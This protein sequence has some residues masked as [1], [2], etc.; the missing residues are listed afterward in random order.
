MEG[1]R[2]RVYRRLLAT[3]RKLHYAEVFLWVISSAKVPRSGSA[4]PFRSR[5]SL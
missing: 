4:G 5:K 3:D 2:I 1:L